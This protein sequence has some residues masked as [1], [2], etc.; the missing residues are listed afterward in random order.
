MMPPRA[1]EES[2]DSGEV[3]LDPPVAVV[4]GAVMKVVGV[5]LVV[6]KLHD[7]TSA[8]HGAARLSWQYAHFPAG[9]PMPRGLID[10][11]FV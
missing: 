10:K 1:A 4:E 5:V 2:P 6:G 8:Q 11:T 7:D 3:G 9:E